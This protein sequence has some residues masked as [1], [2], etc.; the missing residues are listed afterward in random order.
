MGRRERQREL[1]RRRKRHVT[2]KKLREKFSKALSDEMKEK[3]INKA[4]KVSP[5]VV[6]GAE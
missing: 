3:L 5:F 6:L 4:F 1:A 2:V